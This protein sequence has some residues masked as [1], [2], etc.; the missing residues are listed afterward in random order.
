MNRWK[1]AITTVV[2]VAATATL[3]LWANYRNKEFHL[4]P[5]LRCL[6]VPRSANDTVRGLVTG[7][8]YAL[9]ESYASSDSS[10][11]VISIERDLEAALD[12][13]ENSGVSIVSVPFSPDFSADS[14]LVSIPIDSLRIWVL[15]SSDTKHMK[16]LNEWIAGYCSSDAFKQIREKFLVHY[17]P[18]AES[19]HLKK[20][21]YLSPYDDLF[22]EHADSIGWDWR[23]LAAIA[24]QE[25][26]FHIEARSR[27]GA[28]GLMQLMPY[29]AGM[30]EVAN[31]LDPD[32]SIG[33]SARHLKRLYR[34]YS[35][36]ADKTERYKFTLAAYNAGEGHIKDCIT[37]AA[38]KGI[39]PRRWE[40][41]AE[42]IP[43]MSSATTVSEPD[44]LKYKPFK[45]KETNA[46]VKRVWSLYTIFCAMCEE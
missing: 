2:I 22:R 9:L 8:E 20:R 15:S 3:T 45:G 18:I 36:A 16:R 43:E 35:R 23:L 13:L 32:E 37:Y 25:S 26:H 6:I 42:I 7:Y 14:L 39:E 38:S 31:L 30:F 5:E 27:R 29:T 24:Y 41:I 33:A 17:D 44:S 4:D 1:A 46:Y 12:S 34:F 19:R 28:S 10:R 21:E 40:D 11:A